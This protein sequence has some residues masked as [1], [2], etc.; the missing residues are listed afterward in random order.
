M[1]I[2]TLTTDLG[3]KDH[4]VAIVKGEIYS[5][6]EDINIVDIS[7]E[8]S[9][10]NIQEAAFVFKN[11]YKNFPK[12]TIHIIGVN[13][14]LS[15]ENQHVAIKVN[16]QYVIGPD[17]GI[18]S[19][20]FEETYDMKI[21][22]LNISQETDNFTFAIKDIFTK[23]ACHLARGGTLEIIGSPMDDFTNKGSSLKAVTEKNI[24]KGIIT[25]IDSYGNA[26]TNISKDIF[27]KIGFGRKFEILYGRENEKIT[28]IQEK[29][30]D[31]SEGER[32]ALFSYND[33]L[34]IAIN[35]G[36]ANELLG[37]HLFDIIRVEFQ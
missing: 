28:N 34:E 36:K 33:L 37:L 9:K 30:K 15:S 4:Y 2:I 17:N 11:A 22:Q 10:F 16:D 7:H 31:V 35:Q 6:I 13:E 29:Y 27:E 19:L 20:I 32:L 26:T 24:I 8:I 14:E 18:F 1:R 3:I 23:A 21:V 25:H 12:E 5:Q